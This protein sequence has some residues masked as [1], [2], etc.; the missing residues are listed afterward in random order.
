[1]LGLA[2]VFGMVL[3][4]LVMALVWDRARLG[5]GR[6]MRAKPVRLRAGS[7]VLHTNTI[8]IA[9]AVGFL[10]MGVAVISLA[11]SADM[12]G[13]TGLQTSVGS[14]LTTGATDVL[15]WLDPVPEPLLGIGLLALAGAFVYATLRDRKS[16]RR[17]SAEPPVAEAQADQAAE[18][19]HCRPVGD[20]DVPDDASRTSPH[21]REG[22]AR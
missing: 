14:A 11:A 18:H 15:R 2:F 19:H 20:V 3:P 4:L 6:W 17:S 13:G 10:V 5:E 16:S 7:K 9:V 1:V 12:T 22:I 21:R 8:N